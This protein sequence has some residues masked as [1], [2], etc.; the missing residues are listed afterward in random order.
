VQVRT[1]TKNQLLGQVD[2]AFPGLALAISDVLGTKVGRL[3]AA[4][5]ADPAWLTHVGVERIRAFAARR[6]VHVSRD[7]TVRPHSAIV[8]FD[9]EWELRSA[10]PAR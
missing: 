3:V 9:Q 6:G 10:A 4:Y 1:A 7:V 8:L 2:R 5:F